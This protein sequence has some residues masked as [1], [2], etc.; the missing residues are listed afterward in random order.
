V[1]EDSP[2]WAMGLREG[3]VILEANRQRVRSVDQLTALAHGGDGLQMLRL[4]RGNQ[5]L[6]VMARR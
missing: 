2:A 4:R 3:D 5:L 6:L 1:E